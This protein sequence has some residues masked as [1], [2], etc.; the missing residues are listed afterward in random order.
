MFPQ[1]K[2]QLCQFHQIQTVRTKLTGHPKLPASIELLA[3]ARAMHE[4]DKESFIDA[5][6][7]WY[8]KWADFL[9]E[10]SSN[11]DGKTFYTIS[12]LEALILA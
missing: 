8:D 11:A 2:F 5:P 4:T 10:R 9:A 6:D 7:L 1:Y 12:G 3:I